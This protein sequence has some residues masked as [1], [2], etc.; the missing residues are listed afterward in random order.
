MSRGANQRFKLSFLREILLEETDSEHTITMPVIIEKLEKRG[1]SAE[2]KALYNDIADMHELGVE[3]KGTK[4]RFNYYYNVVKRD[5]S[6]AELKLLVDAIQSSKFI[7]ERKSKELIGKLE[8]FASKYERKRLHRQVVVHGRVKTLN[9]NIFKNVDAIHNA[10]ADN[11]QIHF[12]YLK[13]DVSKRLVEKKN[14]EWYCASPWAL[15]S[16]LCQ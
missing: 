7:T 14:G 8:K 1:V 10:I 4:E 15:I 16:I 6:L 2:R 13:W 12:K 5:F 11:R 9:E 3:V